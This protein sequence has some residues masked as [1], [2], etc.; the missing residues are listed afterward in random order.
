[1][2]RRGAAGPQGSRGGGA[3]EPSGARDRVGLVLVVEEVL[4]LLQ[5]RHAARAQE[6]EEQRHLGL[7][8]GLGLELGLGLGLECWC[9]QGSGCVGCIQRY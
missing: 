6:G 7:G 4:G 9:C 2:A 8:L 5:H 3:A 1:M